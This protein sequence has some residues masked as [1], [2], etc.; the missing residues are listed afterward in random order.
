MSFTTHRSRII[1]AV[2]T[3]GIAW[4]ASCAAVEIASASTI[5]ASTAS[6]DKAPGRG[7][8]GPGDPNKDFGWGQTDIWNPVTSYPTP[9]DG[10]DG[11]QKR[12]GDCPP[13]KWSGQSDSVWEMAVRA[14]ERKCKRAEA[15]KE[16]PRPKPKPPTL[17]KPPSPFE[18]KPP[19]PETPVGI[20]PPPQPAPIPL[21]ATA[22][23][24]AGALAGLAFVRRRK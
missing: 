8:Y 7:G 13:P 1:A 14:A 20:P 17:P 19:Q 16:S 5:N 11:A 18:P 4:L 10:E 3:V 15:P 6:W 9:D 12:P 2:G 22:L 24:L 23:M 21:P